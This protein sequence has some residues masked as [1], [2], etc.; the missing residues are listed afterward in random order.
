MNIINIVAVDSQYFSSQLGGD[1][2][3]FR[4][5]DKGTAGVFLDVYRYETPLIMGVLCLDRVHIIRSAY[6]RFPGELMFFD[7][8]GF[9]PPQF[10]Y[11]GTRFFLAHLTEDEAKTIGN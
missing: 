2:Y 4:L 7:Q 5:Q 9:S 3:Q 1:Y 6:K 8:D 11:F 10:T